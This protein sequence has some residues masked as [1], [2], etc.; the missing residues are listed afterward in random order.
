MRIHDKGF[1]L[2]LSMAAV[3]PTL[4]SLHIMIFSAM[5]LHKAEDTMSL[6]FHSLLQFCNFVL[7]QVDLHG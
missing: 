3:L 5:A 2:L 6:S 4:S 7:K 1:Q